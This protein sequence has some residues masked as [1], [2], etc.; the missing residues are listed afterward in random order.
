M[1]QRKILLQMLQQECADEA[2]LLTEMGV[3]PSFENTALLSQ[4]KK[5]AKGDMSAV[6]YIRELLYEE[7]EKPESL[8]ELSALTDGELLALLEQSYE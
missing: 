7:T 8:P 4:V 2:Q 5:A 1:D 6:K 3:A